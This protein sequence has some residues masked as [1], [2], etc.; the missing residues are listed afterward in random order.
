LGLTYFEW[1]VVLA[2]VLFAEAKV[3][4]GIFEVGLG[5]RYDAANTL[6]PELSLIT[7]ISRDH[8]QYLGTTIEQISRE[9]VEISRSGR[10]LI[11][12]AS[13]EALRVIRDHCH[14]IG[15]H[16]TEIVRPYEGPTG[17]KGSQQ[18]RNAAL[19]LKAMELLDVRLPGDDIVSALNSA[20]LPGRLEYIGDH[21]VLDVA[22]NPSSMVVLVQHLEAKGFSGVGVVGI[23]ADKE[24]EILATLLKQACS[25]LYIAQVASER[26]WGS[27]EM[28]KI[29]DM[30]GVTRCESI[31]DA[32][33]RAL[34]TGKDIV[35]TGSFLTIGALRHC[36]ICHAC[37]F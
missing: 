12:T 36:I 37:I 26:S 25:H 5:G 31:P 34:T 9:K 28:E 6:D 15:A 2:V 16:L 35:V 23:L 3:D 21:I 27:R 13:G 22:H 32:F 30:G 20:F 7:D 14:R 33:F 10:P 17:M 19:A 29:R 4:I 8:T 18:G 11:T 1:C 24:Y